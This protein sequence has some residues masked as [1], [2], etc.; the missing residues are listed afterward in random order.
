[1]LAVI[2]DAVNT[3]EPDEDECS[4][5]DVATVNIGAT[6][7]NTFGQ[8]WNTVCDANGVT[9]ALVMTAGGLYGAFQP[10]KCFYTLFVNM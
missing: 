2:T 7:I 6:I 9:G 8:Y 5:N 3:F 1:M 10:K 4:C